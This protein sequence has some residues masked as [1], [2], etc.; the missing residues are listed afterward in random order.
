M[1]DFPVDGMKVKDESEYQRDGSTRRVRV[2]TFYLG[3]HGP[4]TERVAL[5]DYDSGEIGRRV[6]QLR[7]ELRA[8]PS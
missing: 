3:K 6:D 4:F 7:A 5:D 1:D 2:F 8:L